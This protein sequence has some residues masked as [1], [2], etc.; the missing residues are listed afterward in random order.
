MNAL[1]LCLSLAAADAAPPPERLYVFSFVGEDVDDK[2]VGVLER[3]VVEAADDAGF[4]A[5]SHDEIGV[6]LDVEAA[7]QLAGCN[8]ADSCVAEIAG[9]LG[10]ARVVSGKVTRLG[11]TTILALTLTDAKSASVVARE[12]IEGKTSTLRQETP[13]AVRRLLGAPELPP[14]PAPS[15]PA[16]FVT[17]GVV[18]GLGVAAV[19]VGAIPYAVA[20]GA[21]STALAEADKNDPLTTGAAHD[22]YEQARADWN[23]WG[24]VTASVGAAAVVAGAVVLVVAA[25]E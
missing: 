5:V 23:S 13:A 25:V 17:G 9:S 12:T 24:V 4:D 8:A 6:L 15:S 20:Q 22:Q 11:G 2:V 16:L 21:L 10:V 18:A 14:P 7:K 3:A 19:V 1:L